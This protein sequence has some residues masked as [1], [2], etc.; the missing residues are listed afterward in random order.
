MAVVCL[1]VQ[2]LALAD[3]HIACHWCV[4]VLAAFGVA[5]LLPVGC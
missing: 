5:L 2:A 4:H 3:K 1:A